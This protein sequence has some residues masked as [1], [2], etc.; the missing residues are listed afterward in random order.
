MPD[1]TG[2]DFHAELSRVA[3]DLVHRIIFMTG[4]AFTARAQQFLSATL[5][6]HIEKPF[7]PANLRAI[8]QRHLR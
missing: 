5:I 2:M 1:M 8:I 3:P 7:H 6:E 4:G